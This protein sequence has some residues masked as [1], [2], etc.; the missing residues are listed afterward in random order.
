MDSD[1]FFGK[2]MPQKPI[3]IIGGGLAGLSL[4]VFLRMTGVPVT[5][6]EAGRYPRHRVCGEVLSGEGAHVLQGLGLRDAAL[7]AGGLLSV[8]V[9]FFLPNRSSCRMHLPTP[10]LCICRYTLD[11]LLADRFVELGGD[12]RVGERWPDGNDPPQPGVVR[13]SGRV[14]HATDNGCR[15]FGLKAHAKNVHLED[16]IE[17]HFLDNSY[18]GLCRL[19]GGAVNVCGLFRRPARSPRPTPS[20]EAALQGPPGSVL[21]DRLANAIWDHESVCGVAALSVRPGGGTGSEHCRIGDASTMIS[22]LT[23]NGMSMAFQAGELAAE[24]MA[25]YSRGELAWDDARIGLALAADSLF[26][27]RLKWGWRLHQLVFSKFGRSALMTVARLDW[28]RR[29]LFAVTR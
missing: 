17:M 1:K 14:L 12:L 20:W 8:S 16:D 25:A 26:E 13:A 11:R 21:R 7:K 23:G 19:D 3:Q 9:G 29:H 27:R 18:V 5:I 24:W 2:R 6:W 15:W 4:G 28:T 22:P 10:A